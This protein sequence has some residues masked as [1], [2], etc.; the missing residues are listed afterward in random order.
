MS[1]VQEEGGF[2]LRESGTAT[3]RAQVDDHAVKGP[4]LGQLALDMPEHEMFIALRGRSHPWM[5]GRCQPRQSLPLPV[6]ELVMAEV[7]KKF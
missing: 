4:F 3:R 2:G 6:H 5:S 7:A 1:D